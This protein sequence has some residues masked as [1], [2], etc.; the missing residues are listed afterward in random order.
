MHSY[1]SNVLAIMRIRVFWIYFKY[2]LIVFI[3]IK[4]LKNNLKWVFVL[5]MDRSFFSNRHCLWNIFHLV[6][7]ASDCY[8]TLLENH[9]ELLYF[10]IVVILQIWLL[11]FISW[12]ANQI[13]SLLEYIDAFLERCLSIQLCQTKSFKVN[14]SLGL[15]IQILLLPFV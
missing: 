11:F 15:L 14:Q 2:F 10:F 1:W 4:P 5:Y 7:H 13:S 9:K 6:F 3:I 8:T 12:P